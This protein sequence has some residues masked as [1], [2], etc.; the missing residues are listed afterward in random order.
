MEDI[1]DELNDWL[2]SG[3][4]P[5]EGL[6]ILK[7]CVSVFST[8][9]HDQIPGQL[10][11][12]LEALLATIIKPLFA[13][14][15][16]PYPYAMRFSDDQGKLWK[17]FAPWSL[18][19]MK[20]ILDQYS[21]LETHLQKHT[22]ESHFPLLVPP[23]LALLDDADPTQ[24]KFGCSF[25]QV[26]SNHLV[27][28]QSGILTRTGLAKV[29]ED[30]LAPNMLLL[31]SLTPEDQSLEVLG[32]LYPAYRALVQA[33]SVGCSSSPSSAGTFIS[34][35][36]RRHPN[37]R[38][39][40]DQN[41]N[42]QGMLD[43]MLRN[44]I[45]AGYIHASDYAQIAALLVSEIPHTIVMMGASSTKYLPQLLPLLRSILTNPLGAAYQPL[46]RSAV[47]AMRQLIIQCWPRISALW[48]EECTRATVG[49][50]LLLIEEDDGMTQQ[51]QDDAKG[52]MDLLVQVKGQEAARKELNLLQA[53]Y[54]QLEELFPKS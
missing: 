43:R 34:M 38:I 28:C 22:I 37:P 47:G 54:G 41:Q 29:F 44:G 16:A 35:G 40:V 39:D 52:L 15:R 6:P 27:H 23:I 7:E 13:K 51:L 53:E 25:L 42:R 26:L 14:R 30:S 33:S 2:S 19:V 18:D 9:V 45:L 11:A 46:L 20:W 32:S 5:E 12:F 48:W 10:P 24:K 31:P 3:R 49:L 17:D 1:V 8:Y 50:W 21:T 36:Q 4:S